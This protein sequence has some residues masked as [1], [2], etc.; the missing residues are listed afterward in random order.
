MTDVPPNLAGFLTRLGD[1]LDAMSVDG[2]RLNI[3][4]DPAR[5]TPSAAGE[6]YVGLGAWRGPSGDIVHEGACL[7]NKGAAERFGWKRE[8]ATVASF[9]RDAPDSLVDEWRRAFGTD[10]PA[11]LEGATLIVEDASPDSVMSVVFFLARL[12]GVERAELP[13]RWLT[14]LTAWERDGVAPSVRRSWTAL[15]S[16]LAHSHFGISFDTGGIAEAWGDALRFTVALLRAGAD[17][18]AVDPDAV[19]VLLTDTA[20]GRAIAFA[21][22]ERQDYEQSL[23]RAVRL[24]LLVPMAG[25]PGRELLVDA[26][27]ATESNAPSGVKKIFIRTDTE[28]TTLRNGFSLMGLFRPGLEGTGNDMTVSV[29]PR[30]GIALKDLWHALEAS[31]NE[32]WEGA[33]PNAAPRRIASYPTGGYD[34]PWW[35]DHGRYTLLGAP[36]R[37]AADALGS[38][39]SWTDVLEAVWRSYNQLRGL[40]VYDLGEEGQLQPKRIED[41]IAR[42]IEAGKGETA[43]V[44]HL[45]AVK[46]N[47]SF[48]ATQSLQFTPTV[49]RHLA[50]MVIR[51]GQ[52]KTGAV[53]LTDLPEPEDFDYVE[54]AGGEA[55]V[56]RDGVLLF[57]DWRD[58]DLAV[59]ALSAD[60]A[61]AVVLLSECI[62]FGAEVDLLYES[63][64]G[65]ANVLRKITDLRARIART[66][67]K[68]GLGEASAERRIVRE[69]LENRWGLQGKEDALTTRLKDLQE[70]LET[71]A[72]LDTQGMATLLAFVTI[73]AFVASVLQLYGTLVEQGTE[74]EG[75]VDFVGYSL[76]MGGLLVV[77]SALAMILAF[78]L[79]K[80]RR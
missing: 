19:P 31:E 64:A 22:N 17:P 49:K 7:N 24:E 79:T 59:P 39:L 61:Q 45:I 63:A 48:G 25:S 76:W 56:T 14:A 32:K 71:K 68:A 36:K 77:L 69:A 8:P 10:A 4:Y 16:A 53:P 72:T 6:V 73:P 18:D 44:K 70:I 9:V 13:Q 40:A 11:A 47:R 52:G 38:R 35:D 41:C 65:G 26:Y 33:R 57:D 74:T 66:F 54:I 12:S 30:S 21:M 28:N 55:I 3:V 34:Q 20:Y 78:L 43:V 80:Q 37:I 50:A 46:W 58:K 5:R 67:Q 23:A 1:A 29:D 75:G 51:A 15:L 27:F 42:R 60:F 62:A 2:R